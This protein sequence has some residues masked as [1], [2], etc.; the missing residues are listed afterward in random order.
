MFSSVDKMIAA[1]VASGVALLVTG[2]YLSEDQAMNLSTIMQTGIA[3]AV[4]AFVTW[5]VPNKA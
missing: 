5:L 1:F 2:G 3:A 4:T